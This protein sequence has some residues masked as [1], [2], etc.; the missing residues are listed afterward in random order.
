MSKKLHRE[1]E[2]C[3][4]SLMVSLN[5]SVSQMEAAEKCIIPSFSS[6]PTLS[7]T[8]AKINIMAVGSGGFLET[9]SPQTTWT[10]GMTKGM[11]PKELIAELKR[12]NSAPAF[13]EEEEDSL[14][15]G[16]H[17]LDV[18]QKGRK[19]SDS[20]AKLSSLP[21]KDSSKDLFSKQSGGLMSKGSGGDLD[22]L[23][24]AQVKFC[25]SL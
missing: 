23:S 7:C 6:A 18:L 13:E 24:S 19:G 11:A 16:S 25:L 2:A 14:P 9:A 8:Q 15:S 10:A 4:F 20:L 22:T 1:I 21:P 12:N 3:P 5:I 17:P